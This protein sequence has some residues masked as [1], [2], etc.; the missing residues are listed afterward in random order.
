VSYAADDAHRPPLHGF[1]AAMRAALGTDIRRTRTVLIHLPHTRSFA[2]DRRRCCWTLAVQQLIDISCHP[3]PQQQTRRTL[4]QRSTD[5]TDRR[6]DDGH[7][8]YIDHAP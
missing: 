7:T 6:T 4:L 8:P 5:G 1:A 2:A 3:G